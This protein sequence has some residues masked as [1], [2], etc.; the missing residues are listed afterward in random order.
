MKLHVPREIMRAA[1][2]IGMAFTVN[3]PKQVLNPRI[4]DEAT[5]DGTFA[6]PG[7]ARVLRGS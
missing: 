4:E 7:A 1:R 5:F 3:S 6:H 2:L